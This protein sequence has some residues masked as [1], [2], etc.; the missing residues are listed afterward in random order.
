MASRTDQAWVRGSLPPAGVFED[1]ALLLR[2]TID[3]APSTTVY[4]TDESMSCFADVRAW[5][6]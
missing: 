6:I 5:E 1:D 2:L 4:W 3:H